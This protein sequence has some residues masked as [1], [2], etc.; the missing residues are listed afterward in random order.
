MNGEEVTAKSYMK[1]IGVGAIVGAVGGASAQA[2]SSASTRFSSEATKAITRVGVQGASAAA[3]DVGI[4]LY[5]TGEVD[6]K[7]TALNT[8]GQLAVATTA[9]MSSAAAQRTNAYANK[10][11]NQL[12]DEN[13]RK[14]NLSKEAA[15]EIKDRM[16]SLNTAEEVKPGGKVGDG[17]AHVLEDRAN[18]KRAGQVAIDFGSK[19]ESGSRGGGRIIAE[20]INGKQIYVDHTT[21]HDYKG[22]RD[23]MRG[24]L[25]NPID[26][27]KT[28]HVKGL[29]EY[30]ESCDDDEQSNEKRKVE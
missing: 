25:P 24:K 26:G 4:Q 20:K 30:E 2:A 15:Q 22:C 21:E 28:V 19:G 14:D 17:N 10:V 7:Q 12:V 16:K 23:T 6:F 11:N 18:S 9:E 5:Q 13:V 1:S 8:T 27:L 3:T 29:I